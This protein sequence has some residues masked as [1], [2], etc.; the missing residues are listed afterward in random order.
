MNE[1]KVMSIE[2]YDILI[3]ENDKYIYRETNKDAGTYTMYDNI[4]EVHWNVWGTEYFILV[5]GVYYKR[6]YKTFQVILESEKFLEEALLSI[7]NQSIHLKFKGLNGTYKFVR[8]ELHVTWTHNS[9][10]EIF[11]LYQFGRKFSSISVNYKKNNL[12]KRLVKNIAIVFPQFHEVEENN[13]F[14]G[15]GFTEWTLLEP[16]P[17]K[18]AD[19]YIKKPHKDIGYYNLKDINHRSYMEK[20]ANNYDIHGFCYYHYWFKNKK[21]MYEP[22]ELM[23][24]D[25][26]PDKPF[27]FCWANEQWTRKWDG[28]NNEV[29][30]EQDYSDVNGNKAHFQYLLQF[31]QHKNYIIIN[32]KPVF[33]FYRIEKKDKKYIEEIIQQWNYLA[34]QHNFAGIYFM[35][36][37]GP[38]DNDVHIE[39]IQGH[40]NFEPGYVTQKHGYEFNSYNKNHLLFD[41]H[42]YNETD[43]LNKNRDV[44]ELVR[45]KRLPNGHTHFNSLNTHESLIRTS[46]FTVFDGKKALEKI[47]SYQSEYPYQNYGLFVGWNN[48]PRRNYKNKLYHKYPMYYDNITDEV[49]GEAYKKILKKSSDSDSDFI[50]ITSWNE[51]NEQSSLEP[52]HIDGYNYLRQIKTV[53][54]DFYDKKK[55]KNILVFSHRGGGTE[56]YINDLI[57]L[58]PQYNF[59]YFESYNYQINYNE[60]HKDI[61][62]IHINSFY[63]IES[64]FDYRIFFSTYFLS[65]KK[66]L[67][68]HDYQW[69]YPND[70]NILSY[71]MKSHDIK[72]DNLNKFIFLCRIIDLIIFPS[73]N[74]YHNYKKFIDLDQF[75]DKIKI[76]SHSDRMISHTI[77]N[78]PLIKNIINISFVGNF[79]EYKGSD[80]FRRL[81]NNL[82]YYQGYLI[83][84][85]VF[86]YISN[87]EKENK[88][89]H[90]NFIYHNE[91]NDVSISQRL[92]EEQIHLITHLS[93]F[94]ESYCYALTNSILSGL[95]ILYLHHGAFS[96]RLIKSDKY[97]PTNI[98]EIFMNYQKALTYII[99]NQG[100]ISDQPSNTKIQPTKW[101]LENY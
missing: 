14:W 31:F 73:M 81:F 20:L 52:N 84:Y 83:R 74:I 21:V 61:Q 3:T 2:W 94:E 88:I 27:M 66:I 32:N 5:N 29:L 68:I 54:Q 6:E 23:L 59:V 100:K 34:I 62:M 80:L 47:D 79:I 22:L 24:I 56:K 70:P 16:M 10:L 99:N 63:N 97:F 40:I 25:G 41:K 26:K 85:H 36:F 50:F 64:S 77:Y 15:K 45:N 72:E 13:Q 86:G 90:D 44:N 33:I 7:E 12:S 46:K 60:I 17:E 53:Y 38:F 28:G 65:T 49:F 58:F 55:E 92:I 1:L 4:L 19:Q 101:Y 48:S 78:I 98:D 9:K 95:P 51:W 43:Y 87:E 71:N 91:Y 42:H 75:K 69:L 82:K 89:Y 11:Y 96:E 76:E 57:Y 8:N 39:G 37:L 67:T 93:I 18:V 35:R 30:I